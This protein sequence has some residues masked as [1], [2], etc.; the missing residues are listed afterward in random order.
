MDIVATINRSAG[1]ETIGDMWKE[2]AV[3]PS[4]TP[5]AEVMIWAADKACNVGWEE[6]AR[7]NVQLSL[8]QKPLDKES[9]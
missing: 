3:F 6:N 8:A 2:T 4:D 1:N 9:S 7:F 5:I